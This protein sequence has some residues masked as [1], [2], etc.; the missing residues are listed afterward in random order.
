[1]SENLSPT[2][3]RRAPRVVV[4]GLA[5]CFGCQINITNIERHLM[6]V[7]GQIDLGY[8]QPKQLARP[9]TTTRG[10]RRSAVGDRFSLIYI[11]P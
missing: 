11:D 5:S 10:A 9:I 4:I 6:N 1:M 3:E 7:L 8:W 2:A